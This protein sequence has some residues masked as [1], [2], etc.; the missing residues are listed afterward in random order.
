MF[1]D[2]VSSLRLLMFVKSFEKK[3]IDL[4]LNSYVV[5]NKWKYFCFISKMNSL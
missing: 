5:F 3:V 2:I 4:Y 1:F